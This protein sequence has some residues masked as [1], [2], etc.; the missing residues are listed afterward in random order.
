MDNV[1]GEIRGSTD[2]GRIL[3]LTNKINWP[4]DLSTDNGSIE[5]KT[6]SEPTNA[7]INAEVGNGK[8]TIFGEET[9][10]KTFGKGES[11]IKL[12]TDNGRITVT[13]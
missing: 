4:I 6:K 2:N 1:E 3:L 5:I 12:Q 8:I 9:K 10:L 13:K 7:T 11:L